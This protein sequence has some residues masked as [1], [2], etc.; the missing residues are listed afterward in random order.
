M[1]A[2]RD[3]YEVLGVPKD[4]DENQIKRAFWKLAKK[5]HP[6]VNKDDPEAEH[7]FK[8]ANEA[9]EVL[10]NKE[11]RQR[12]DQFGHAGVDG[13]GFPGGGFGFE[14][15]NIEDIFSSIF[16]G[17]FGGM[18]GFGG[19]GRR[20]R[21]GPIPGANLRYRMNLDFMEAAFGT[22]R[23]IKIK[24]ED[25]CKKCH[26]HGTAD[27]NPAPVCPTCQGAGQVMGV[28]QTVFG[29]VRT[30]QTCPDCRGTGKKIEN[31]C[32]ECRGSG[33][34]MINKQL[35]VTVPAGINERE[36]LTLTGEGEP[37][38]LGVPYGDLYIEIHI[39][40]H[41][42]FTRQGTTTLCSVP[43]TFAQAALGLE[44]MVP[45]IDGS[46]PYQLKAGTQPGEIITMRNMGIPY[47][48]RPHLR[49]DHKFQ[50]E[51]EVPHNLNKEQQELLEKFEATME[52]ENYKKRTG[53]F[54]KI[55]G[56]FKDN[57]N[58]N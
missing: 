24:K 29:Q 17:G 48:N 21:Q 7:K 4:A 36:M 15:I 22:E 57:E 16:G 32:S 18:G 11:K 33:R 43:V 42:V 12:Y 47:I 31:P 55:K 1:S 34:T 35:K 58:K 19:R 39:K 38:T 27:G 52:D 9:Y 49:G 40:P 14:D 3:Y 53:F 54:E 50:V 5:Y 46:K 6:D 23:E 25:I 13:Q 37:G 45:T 56:L 26:G 8:E 10:S 51:L 44:I 2:K 20:G 28:Q 41:P 30:N